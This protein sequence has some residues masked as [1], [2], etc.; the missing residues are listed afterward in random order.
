MNFIKSMFYNEFVKT[1]K[2]FKKEKIKPLTLLLV[3][4]NIVCLLISNIIAVKTVAL[5][6]TIG[7][8]A[9][10]VEFKLPA[11]V[12]MYGLAIITSDLLCQI[13]PVWSRRSCH[14]GFGLNL[15]MVLTF[16]ATIFLPGVI[17]GFP[18][19]GMDSNIGIV[20]GSSWFMLVA[21]MLSFY[22]GDLAN[23]TV[24]AK[25]K[26]KEGDSNSKILK[27]CLLSTALGQLLDSSIFITFGLFLLPKW[28]LGTPFIGF[29]YKTGSYGLWGGWASVLGSI[30][31]QFLVKILLEFILS[32]VILKLC[33]K[34]KQKDSKEEKSILPD[35]SEELES[36]EESI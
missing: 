2:G 8:G 28:I 14:I 11:A 13:D 34:A 7:S 19:N 1:W 17:N 6:G 15:F 21:S 26:K 23:D 3:V 30:A 4:F 20:L 22:F 35:G 25:L 31:L 18:A 27:R 36:E 33:N 29:D 12:I 32:P 5:W 24:F 10:F 9:S 16:T